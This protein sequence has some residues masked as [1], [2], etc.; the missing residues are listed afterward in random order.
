VSEVTT[1]VRNAVFRPWH[2]PTIALPLVYCSVGGGTM[3]DVSPDSAVSDVSS[4]CCCYGNHAAGSKP[5]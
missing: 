3:F 2:R 1:D 4:R 5:I